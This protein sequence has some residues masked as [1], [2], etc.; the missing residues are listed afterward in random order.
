MCPLEEEVGSDRT[1]VRSAIVKQGRE[2]K[3]EEHEAL[4]PGASAGF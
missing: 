1:Q 2:R 3:D 4:P